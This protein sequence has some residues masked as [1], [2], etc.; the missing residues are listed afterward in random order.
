V[1]NN[2]KRHFVTHKTPDLFNPEQID[3]LI[4]RKANKT[5]FQNINNKSTIMNK[6]YFN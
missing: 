3:N 1:A 4:S 6:N 2:Y 5:F